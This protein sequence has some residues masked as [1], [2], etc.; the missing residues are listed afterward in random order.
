[1]ATA[2]SSFSVT[3]TSWKTANQY[4]CQHLRWK[5]ANQ[6][7][8]QHLRNLKNAHSIVHAQITSV[9]TD[10]RP[11]TQHGESVPPG[12]TTDSSSQTGKSSS[13]KPR[14]WSSGTIRLN[15]QPNTPIRWPTPPSDDQPNPP[16]HLMTRWTAQHTL[17]SDNPP[18][19]L[20]TRWTAQHT[21]PSDD[22]PP[23]WCPDEQPNTPLHLMT[24]RPPIWRPAQHTPQSNDPPLHLMTRWTAQH[25]PP[26]DNPPLHLMTRWTAQHTPP[27]NDHPLHLMTR[28]KH[29]QCHQQISL[30]TT[31]WRLPSPCPPVLPWSS[32]HTL[33]RPTNP[34]ACSAGFAPFTKKH[35]HS[36]GLK[37]PCLQNSSGAASK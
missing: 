16:L 9:H 2:P 33:D 22:T 8:C 26:S 18:L 12:K 7:N 28:C 36:F 24:P 30:L 29:M 5:T 35:G 34:K 23:I 19:H 31:D 21:P 37:E 4:N 6:Y 15:G 25:T 32:H 10:T 3:R 1:M 14:L 17:P 20:M 13:G 27:S 11:K